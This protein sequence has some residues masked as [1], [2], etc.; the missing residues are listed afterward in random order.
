MRAAN[1]PRQAR[2]LDE[3]IQEHGL[4]PGRYALFFVTGEGRFHPPAA[5]PEEAIEEASGYVL[6]DRGRVFA[7][8]LGWDDRRGIPALTE[9]REEAPEPAWHDDEEYR[10]ARLAVGLPED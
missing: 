6:D 1:R 10:R 7:F 2:L 4:K 9:W 5:E 3:L 8:W